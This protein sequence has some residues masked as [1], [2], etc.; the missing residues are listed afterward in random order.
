MELFSIGEATNVNV[1]KQAISRSTLNEKQIEAILVGANLEKQELKT[2]T[3][4]LANITSTN[5]MS[6]SQVGATST[7]LT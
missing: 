3:A 5:A 6:A 1:L 4:E 2:T 7:T